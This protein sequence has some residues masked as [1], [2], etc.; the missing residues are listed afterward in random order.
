M[1][2]THRGRLLALWLAWAAGACGGGPPARPH[3]ILIVVDSLRADHL[4]AYGYARPTSPNFDRLA[5]Q[6]TLFV[7][8]FAIQSGW[9]NG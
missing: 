8:A 5:D 1:S 7:N 4:G 9:Y 3:L 6:G 2:G